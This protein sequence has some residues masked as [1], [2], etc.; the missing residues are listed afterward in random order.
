MLKGDPGHVFPVMSHR[1]S[2]PPLAPGIFA[3]P[4]PVRMSA[5]LLVLVFG[6]TA[7][8]LAMTSPLTATLLRRSTKS[9]RSTNLK[10]APAP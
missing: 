2:T 9:P 4:P 3:W 7:T 6:L 10:R 1:E 8:P 5:P